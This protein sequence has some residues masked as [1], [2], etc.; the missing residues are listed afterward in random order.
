MTTWVK[1]CGLRTTQDVAVA[2]EAGADAVGLMLADSPRQIT[3]DQAKLLAQVA[4]AVDTVLVMANA[5]VPE[6]R[7]A[8]LRTGATGVQAYGDHSTEVVDWASQQGLLVLQPFSVGR[9]PIA[10]IVQ[11]EGVI[12]LFDTASPDRLGG[13][14]HSFDWSLVRAFSSKFVLAGGLAPENVAKAVLATQ[15]WGVDASSGLESSPGVKD[16]H[17]I[18]AFIEGA[19]QNEA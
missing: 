2:V 8:V 18:R 3:V 13:S 16:H 1:V 15:A 4:G 6:V 12:P 5:S 11:L 17:K 7:E 19:K 14:G 10:D 9:E